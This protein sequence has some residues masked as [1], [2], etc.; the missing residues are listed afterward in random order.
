MKTLRLLAAVVL[1]LTFALPTAHAKDWKKVVIATEGAYM[2]FNGH[3]PD[4]K[5]I[6]F[7]IDLGNNLCERMKITCEFVAQDWDGIIPGLTAGKY[8]AIMDGMSITAKR[9]E[10]I[11][12]SRN[13][14]RTP[15]TFAVEKK[16]PL[17]EMPDT[18]KAVSLDDKAAMDA[19]GPIVTT[20]SRTYEE[21]AERVRRVETWLTKHIPGFLGPKLYT[22][23][24]LYD[25][26]RDRN[27]VID[28]L[29]D[30]PQILVCNG[31]GHAYKFASLLGK[32]LSELAIDG[33]TDSP[34]APF[35]IRRPAITDPGYPV[36][37]H[38]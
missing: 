37:F 20:D 12:F 25:M 7:E 29:P 35:T 14:S 32:V 11:D 4:G 38:L 3:S 8:D 17:A 28:A 2:P 30:H 1:T 26:P 31:A 18:G 36:A 13:Y 27:F 34:I 21:D 15:T 9:Q 23:T 22:K 16:G 19:A 5:L 10:V 24:C 6:G 33:R